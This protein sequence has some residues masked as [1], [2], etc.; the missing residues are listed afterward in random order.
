MELH[1]KRASLRAALSLPKMWRVSSDGEKT[2]PEAVPV[3][4]KMRNGDHCLRR[5]SK[6]DPIRG[7]CC[8]IGFQK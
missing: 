7:N 6:K 2:F 5:Q 4:R 1:I 8:K 3:L